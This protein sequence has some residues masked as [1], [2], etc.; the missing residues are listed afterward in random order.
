LK[1]DETFF[2]KMWKFSMRSNFGMTRH[3]FEDLTNISTGDQK[4]EKI[5]DMSV[6][7]TTVNYWFYSASIW[8]M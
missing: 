8:P 7:K 3:F 6:S 5:I 1:S 4:V 2:Q